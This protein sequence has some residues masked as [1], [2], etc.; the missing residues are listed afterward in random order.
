MCCVQADG[1]SKL[2]TASSD[3]SARVFDADRF[4]AAHMPPHSQPSDAAPPP[5]SA[6][7]LYTLTGHIGGVKSVRPRPDHSSILATAGRDGNLDVWDL[8]TPPTKFGISLA[9]TLQANRRKIIWDMD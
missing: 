6:F 8:R 2:L 4:A 7:C 5:A 9:T 1:D 3:H